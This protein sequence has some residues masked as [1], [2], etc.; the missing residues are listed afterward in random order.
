MNEW[1]D[2]WIGVSNTRCNIVVLL[3]T[4]SE[5]VDSSSTASPSSWDEC[6]SLCIPNLLFFW[7]LLIPIPISLM[8]S[9][10]S[11]TVNSMMFIRVLMLKDVLNKNRETLVDIVMWETCKAKP[12]AEKEVD[13]R[14]AFIEK[15]VKIYQEMEQ[16]DSK[17]IE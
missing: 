14:M 12:D 3:Q 5:D 1:M 13:R 7:L 2:G 10:E 8:E 15:E 9:S 17:I 6:P 11:G 16:R 4:Q